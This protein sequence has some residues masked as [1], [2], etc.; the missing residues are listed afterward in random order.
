MELE[1]AT[2]I[3][4]ELVF[5]CIEV[6]M[7]GDEVNAETLALALAIPPPKTSSPMELGPFRSS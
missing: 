7:D 6:E 1:E 5:T 4:L 2:G 3:E